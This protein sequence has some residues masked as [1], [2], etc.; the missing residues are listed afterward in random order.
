MLAK[1]V[2]ACFIDTNIWLYAFVE[3]GETAKTTKLYSE[4]LQNG[5]LIQGV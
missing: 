4:D 3:S 2:D 5:L 1:S